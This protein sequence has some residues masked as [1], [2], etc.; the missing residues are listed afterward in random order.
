MGKRL[1]GIVL[2]VLVV[3]ASVWA[4]PARATAAYEAKQ[5]GRCAALWLEATGTKN[6]EATVDALYHAASCQAMDRNADK[7][8]ATLE[9]AV[10]A[11][12]RDLDRLLEDKDLASLR[13][14]AR[15]ER[16]LASVRARALAWEETLG[17]PALRRELLALVKEDQAARLAFIQSG[18]K[19]KAAL[20]RVA[21]LDKKS[22]ARLREIVT[23]RGWPGR[24]L[25]GQDG[26]SAAWLLVQHADADRAFQKLCLIKM[27]EAVKRGEADASEWAYL[28][29]RVAVGEHRKQTYG[30][31]LNEKQEPIP[32]EDEAHV[33]ER[34]KA[35]GLPSMAEYRK[36]MRETYGAPK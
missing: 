22:T 18:F 10:A 15:W 26:A 32:I 7:A 11:G 28:V 24:G 4:D 27:E 25:V 31:Q 36:Q 29:D 34:R 12:Y 17:D 6:G 23:A 35:V 30:T 20:L 33:D 14:D 19:D 16:I 13:G 5:F 8:F 9:R 2:G 3:P 21:E 1:I